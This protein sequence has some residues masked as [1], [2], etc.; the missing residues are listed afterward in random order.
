MHVETTLWALAPGSEEQ[1]WWWGHLLPGATQ[2]RCQ[3]GCRVLGGSC[4]QPQ[5]R[6]AAKKRVCRLGVPL[7]PPAAPKLSLN[8]GHLSQ[9]PGDPAQTPPCTRQPPLLADPNDSTFSHYFPSPFSSSGSSFH[10]SQSAAATYPRS[11]AILTKHHPAKKT[12]R[13]VSFSLKSPH[14]QASFCFPLS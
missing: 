4:R 1:P 3:G 13:L 2:R 5:P 14:P 9:E 12:E 8:S 6:F 11:P 7:L 10:V